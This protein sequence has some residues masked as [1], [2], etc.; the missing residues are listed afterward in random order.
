MTKDEMLETINTLRGEIDALSEQSANVQEQLDITAAEET[1]PE[2]GA[3]GVVEVNLDVTDEDP[4]GEIGAALR[5]YAAELA[6]L[7][8]Q[9]QENQDKLERQQEILRGQGYRV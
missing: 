8:E 6:L 1:E 3:A 4:S 5:E 7:R 2:L 9:A